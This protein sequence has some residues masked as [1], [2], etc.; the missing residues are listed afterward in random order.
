MAFQQH[1]KWECHVKAYAGLY[2][3]RGRWLVAYEGH[4]GNPAFTNMANI[5]WEAVKRT[6]DTVR[7]IR[8]PWTE[9][10]RLAYEERR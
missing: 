2:N 5:L 3:R 7:I 1:G 10:E 9:E 6:A 8:R 4:P